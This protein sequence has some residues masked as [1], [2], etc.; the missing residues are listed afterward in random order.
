MMN[1]KIE[2]YIISVD[3]P[4]PHTVQGF[5]KILNE[6]KRRRKNYEYTSPNDDLLFEGK[7]SLITF[8]SNSKKM[9]NR[10]RKAKEAIT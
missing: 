1:S 5:R 7:K 3:R 6:N 8:R 9:E 10:K 2:S 4:Q